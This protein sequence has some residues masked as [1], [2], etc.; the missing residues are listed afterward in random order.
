MKGETFVS[1]AP[2]SIAIQKSNQAP[3]YCPSSSNGYFVSPTS[4]CFFFDEQRTPWPYAG[5]R[6]SITIALLPF[7]TCIGASANASLT[8]DSVSFPVSRPL[9]HESTGNIGA[10]LGSARISLSGLHLSEA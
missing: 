9:N 7:R 6:N 8:C 2:S 1:N 5:L 3:K 4:G 10:P